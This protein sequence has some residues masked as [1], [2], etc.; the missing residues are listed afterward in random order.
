MAVEQKL[1]PLESP[2][3]WRKALIGI[4]HTFGH[5]WEN[6]YAM[7][8]T[9]GLKTYL[10]SFEQDGIKIVCPFA[11]REFK[12]HIDIVK[13]FG[14]SGF[15]GN[16]N[17]PEFDHHWRMLARKQGYV[18]GYLGLN[19][20]FDFSRH[21]DEH[22]IHQ[23][24]TI[25][26]L[27]LTPPIDDLFAKLSAN[28]KRQLKH[29]EALC[30]DLVLDK[31]KLESFFRENYYH[32]LYRKNAPPFYY[33]SEETISF[34]FSLDNVLLVGAQSSGKVVAVS[35][36]TCIAGAGEYLF[37]V[38][39]L[40][41][42]PHAASLVWYAVNYMKSQQIPILNLGGGSVDFKRRFG[43]TALPLKC[44][45]QVYDPQAYEK[46]SRLENAP[47]KNTQGFFPAYR[48]AEF[49]EQVRELNSRRASPIGMEAFPKSGET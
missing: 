11:E 10:Y 27:D 37:N 2:D 21:F 4:N 3:E 6:C 40:E 8:L 5:T 12:G 26:S 7:H 39:L 42:R 14:F 46:L 19:P 1:I 48:K 24:D 32:F 22:T 43:V 34:L 35:V 30:S 25:Y 23:Y 28:R 15:V 9:T 29:W 45:R 47:E 44:L 20:L 13:P 49:E 38:P 33:F 17:C 16:G 18:C 36:F 31:P 41:G